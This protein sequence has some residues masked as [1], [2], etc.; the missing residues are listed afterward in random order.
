MTDSVRLPSPEHILNRLPPGTW[1]IFRHY[2][3]AER[4]NLARELRQ[5]CRVRRLVF[6]VAG[7]PHLATE[8]DADGLHL[9][10]RALLRADIQVRLF[11][12]R[13]KLVS[14]ATHI[15][16]SVRK[17]ERLGLDAALISPIYETASH[18][19]A[20]SL[21]ILR[22]ARMAKRVRI[23]P[24]AL[25][26]INPSRLNRLLAAGA[27]GLAGVSGIAEVA[28]TLSRRPVKAPK[29]V[30]RQPMRPL[31]HPNHLYY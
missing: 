27:A 13:G 4:K 11:Q 8:V 22:F 6:L 26:G 29:R 20:R 12:R 21:G 31:A 7:D 16:A 25:G 14:A 23:R 19:G 30:L 10:E 18:P 28:E 15:P 2:E 5:R 9:P 24:I 17:A 3:T 1:V